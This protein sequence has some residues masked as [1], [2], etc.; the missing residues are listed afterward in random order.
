LN[1]SAAKD[2]GRIQEMASSMAKATEEQQN[3][4]KEVLTAMGE[5]SYGADRSA[6]LSDSL[7]KELLKLADANKNLNKMIKELAG[8]ID[9]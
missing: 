1:S 3:G 8:G 4:T 2:T 9:E 5:L 6:A 7:N